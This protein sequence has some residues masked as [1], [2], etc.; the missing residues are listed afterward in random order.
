MGQGQASV[1]PGTWGE[2]ARH[3]WWDC[4]SSPSPAPPGLAGKGR[5]RGVGSYWPGLLETGWNWR[6]P[7]LSPALFHLSPPYN[8]PHCKLSPILPPPPSVF[9]SGGRC[10]RLIQARGGRGRW[11]CCHCGCWEKFLGLLSSGK[12]RGGPEEEIIRVCCSWETGISGVF[13]GPGIQRMIVYVEC[14]N[15][16]QDYQML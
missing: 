10:L 9:S 12:L 4:H 13:R 6:D 2:G 8:R 14:F 11:E 3:R 15:F 1:S 5:A 7:T 16:F